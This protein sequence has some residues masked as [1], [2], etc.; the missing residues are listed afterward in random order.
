[1]AQRFGGVAWLLSILAFSSNAQERQKLKAAEHAPD[2]VVLPYKVEPQKVPI[3]T[4]P[5]PPKEPASTT[6]DTRL[7]PDPAPDSRRDMPPKL[8]AGA[9]PTQGSP[10][11]NSS[12]VWPHLIPIPKTTKPIEVTDVPIPPPKASQ[13]DESA[14][15]DPR[16]AN[17]SEPFEPL[18]E[19][20]AYSLV[21]I[22][23]CTLTGFVISFF[24][25]KLTFSQTYGSRPNSDAPRAKPQDTIDQSNT[26]RPSARKAMPDPG[27]FQTQTALREKLISADEYRELKSRYLTASD[28][29]FSMLLP[30]L[31]LMIYFALSARTWAPW[32]IYPSVT[33]VTAFLTTFALDRRHKYQSE[34]RT[35]ILR[36]WR[37]QR[38]EKSL[39]ELLILVTKLDRL[40]EKSSAAETKRI[41]ELARL[42][43]RQARRKRSGTERQGSKKKATD[44]RPSEESDV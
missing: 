34:Y 16:P 40:G 15:P 7:L 13:P 14:P 37:Q 39:K 18:G 10:S 36:N 12:H 35:L 19:T 43:Y 2:Q 31:L 28:L 11:P 27:V 33:V 20:L 6:T 32:W 3:P 44:E 21:G 17:P 1:M 29:S 22:G 25:L 38:A 42:L 8:P 24:L 26:T 41:K 4:K 5:S 9:E 23:L 30:S